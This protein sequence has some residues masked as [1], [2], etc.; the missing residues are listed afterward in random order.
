MT[1]GRGGVLIALAMLLH[2]AATEAWAG[3]SP[4]VSFNGFGTLGLVH[5]NEDQADFVSNSLVDK[6][7]GYSSAWS[8]DVDSRLG[9]QLTADLTS[10]L[11][12][13]VQVVAER[14]YDGTYTPPWSGRTS[15]ST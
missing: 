15:S 11:S 14:R 12:G 1:F 5:S 13:I 9:L 4:S 10:R 3:D 8:A 7:A 6:G 2:G